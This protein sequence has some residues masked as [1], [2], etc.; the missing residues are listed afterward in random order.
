MREVVFQWVH[1]IFTSCVGSYCF[2]LLKSCCAR[3]FSS[4]SGLTLLKIPRGDGTFPPAA[5]HDYSTLES[6][7]IAPPINVQ[8]TI[9]IHINTLAVIQNPRANEKKLVQKRNTG[10]AKNAKRKKISG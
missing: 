2:A 4:S 10:E 7:A 8:M 1:D 3:I 6:K 5:A 9:N